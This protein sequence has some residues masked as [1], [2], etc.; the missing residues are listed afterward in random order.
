M[1]LLFFKPLNWK[2]RLSHAEETLANLHD[3]RRSSKVH[4]LLFL[5]RVSN[6]FPLLV[7]IRTQKQRTPLT[8]WKTLHHLKPRNRYSVRSYYQIFITAVTFGTTAEKETLL[9][10]KKSTKGHWD[11][12]IMIKHA[13]YQHLLERIRLPSMESRRIQDMLLTIHKSIWNKA[14]Q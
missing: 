6:N 7:R 5:S 4:P 14:P 2:A 10:S 13:S 12:S 11:M 3:P 8:D 1:P 9:K